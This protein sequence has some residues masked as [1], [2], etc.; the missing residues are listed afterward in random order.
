MARAAAAGAGAAAMA[1]AATL[2][3]L[4]AAASR[5]E[6]D[7]VRLRGGGASLWQPPDPENNTA[8]AGPRPCVSGQVLG[9]VLK[10]VQVHNKEVECEEMWAADRTLQRRELDHS[11]QREQEQRKQEQQHLDAND[12]EAT[13]RQRRIDRFVGGSSAA[14]T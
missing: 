12:A 5:D 13:R 11:E 4:L 1:R 6:M 2:L 9:R 7:K 14:T 8:H 10:H 3:L